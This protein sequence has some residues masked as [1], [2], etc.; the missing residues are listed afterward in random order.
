MRNII[1]AVAFSIIA[2]SICS[3]V[4]CT[5]F[6]DQYAVD[7]SVGEIKM[8]DDAK[9]SDDG[10]SYTSTVQVDFTIRENS[11]GKISSAII[12]IDG[13]NYDVVDQ[14][15]PQK[16]GVAEIL[17]T[18]ES[19]ES[20]SVVATIKFASHTYENNAILQPKSFANEVKLSTGDA[21]K[22]TPCSAVLNVKANF[23]WLI[24][25]TDAY[26]LVSPVQFNLPV[27]SKID[28]F[29]GIVGRCIRYVGNDYDDYSMYCV[30]KGLN[31]NTTYYYQLVRIDSNSK[32]VLAGETKT[33]KTAETTAKLSTSIANIGLISAKVNVTFDSG[34]LKGL[35]S[36]D[37]N[38]IWRI[39]ESIEEL[40][41]SA[42]S[43]LG[44]S[45]VT[46]PF[47]FTELN[48]ETKY[49]Y[50]CDFYIG[51]GLMCSS[52]IKE[53]TTAESTATVD[54]ESNEIFDTNGV[55]NITLDKGN[56]KN[57]IAPSAPSPY[58]ATVRILCGETKDKMEIKGTVSAYYSN[59]FTLYLNDLCENKKYFYKVCYYA[60]NSLLASSEVLEFTTYRSAD[61]TD[62]GFLN[63]Q[64]WNNTTS[65]KKQ[66]TFSVRKGSVL[67]FNY[68]INQG[69]HS[70]S[71]KL[72]GASSVN[73]FNVYSSSTDWKS[74]R[75]Y[76]VFSK[77]G[78]YTL[79]LDYSLHTYGYVEVPKIKLIY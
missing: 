39:G 65:G 34:N 69:G 3:I 76:Y 71:A 14:L 33:F 41:S 22:I 4:G 24:D 5:D 19:R 2:L 40:E 20:V 59:N 77:N 21:D 66:Y 52:G 62:L 32:V 57:L 54:V 17:C 29:K 7:A 16:G 48:A 74:G 43:K 67:A 38:V 73:L 78:T 18:F 35:Y 58:Y 68:S 11:F 79:L 25:I 42:G 8:K 15:D 1:K 44:A 30:T 12:S 75:V 10:K 27:N 28:T 37:W 13:E 23:P 47:T 36:S 70:L 49:Y 31:A 60:G 26:M 55:F 64:T 51:D 61:I 63:I 72:T 53:F 45:K 46:S 56:T 50:R 9:L 6:P